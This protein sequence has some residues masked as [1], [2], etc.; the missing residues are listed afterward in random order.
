[1]ASQVAK[2]PTPRTIEIKLDAP[3]DGWEATLL[4]SFPFSVLKE[5]QSG[6]IARVCD[7]FDKITIEHNF[8]DLEG[9]RA[10]SSS[11]VSDY[12]AVAQAI[13]KWAEGS[14]RLPPR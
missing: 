14:G 4:A 7:A 1:M 5:L 13:S 6:D 11:D 8:P 2:R 12:D 10:I 9:N 3:F